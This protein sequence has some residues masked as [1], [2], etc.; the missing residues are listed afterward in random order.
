MASLAGRKGKAGSLFAT[1]VLEEPPVQAPQVEE[2]PTFRFSLFRRPTWV[3][4]ALVGPAVIT[5]GIWKTVSSPA[6]H[7]VASI[8]KMAYPL[9]DKP[10]IAVLPFDNLSG[11]PGQ[12]FF[13]DGLTEEIITTLFKESLSFRYRPPL[14]RHLQR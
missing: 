5:W 6:T 10:S 11:D 13:C 1:P 7:Q 12:E 9:P 8:N 14:F 2:P 4:A 3:I